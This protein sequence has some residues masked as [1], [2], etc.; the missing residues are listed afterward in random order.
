MF[1][2]FFSEPA[3]GT[4]EKT[5]MYSDLCHFLVSTWISVL[6]RPTI[7]TVLIPLVCR[8]SMLHGSA[9]L[10]ISNNL[11]TI[12]YIKI[13]Q[14]ILHYLIFIL[15]NHRMEAANVGRNAVPVTSALCPW[16]FLFLVSENQH[17]FH[18]YSAAWPLVC[19]CFLPHLA[20]LYPPKYMV[21]FKVISDFKTLPFCLEWSSC[22]LLEDLESDM[23]DLVPCV[24]EWAH[25]LAGVS[26]KGTCS[27]YISGWFEA[28]DLEEWNRQ[29]Q[30]CGLNLCNPNGP[31]SIQFWK[32]WRL[33]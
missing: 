11:A 4:D 25:F 6:Y 21:F 27:T 18:C 32:K 5:D 22:L 2:H 33:N 16:C 26:S 13:S 23:M 14:I 31:N 8:L 28:C 29:V 20:Y 10:K 15:N 3:N 12:N 19:S 7:C 24:L 1:F 9:S 17:H 30:P